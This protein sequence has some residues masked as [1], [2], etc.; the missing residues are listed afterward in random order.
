MLRLLDKVEIRIR[1]TKGV[2]LLPF[3]ASPDFWSARDG[4]TARNGRGA[5][6]VRRTVLRSTVRVVLPT[7]PRDR[8]LRTYAR[9]EGPPAYTPRTYPYYLPR[10]TLHDEF[11]QALIK[12]GTPPQI[13]SSI[14]PGS[15]YDSH[16]VQ[17]PPTD[18]VYCRLTFQHGQIMKPWGSV[19]QH[20][21]SS[22]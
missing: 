2:S 14:L 1:N 22:Q 11:E 10:H 17:R 9:F 12:R 8:V 7:F 3:M 5:P 15:Q 20:Y 18:T 6:S 4:G 16:I 13:A 21:F 19:F